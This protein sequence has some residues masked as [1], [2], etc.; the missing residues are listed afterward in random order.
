MSKKSAVK[1]TLG[2]LIGV[3]VAAAGY[4]FIFRKT[5]PVLQPSPAQQSTGV[6]YRNATYGFAVALPESWEG[7]SVTIDTWTGDAMGD[8]LGE[9]PFTTG[10]VVSIHNPRWTGASTYQD[11]PIMVFTIDQWNLLQ[12]EKFHIGAAPIGPSEL[13]RNAAYVFALPARYNYSFPPGY[14]EVD[15]I[16]QSKPLTIFEASGPAPQSQA[17]DQLYYVDANSGKLF[18]F[19]GQTAATSSFSAIP[20]AQHSNFVAFTTDGRYLFFDAK[21][22]EDTEPTLYRYDLEK[23]LTT[24]ILRGANVNVAAISPDN[25]YLV[26]DTGCC[27]GDRGRTLIRLENA[28]KIL[29]TTGGDL[30]WSP[31]SKKLAIEQA[32]VNLY[33]ALGSD[34]TNESIRIIYPRNATAAVETLLQGTYGV[35]YKPLLWKDNDTLIYEKI[36]YQKP[37]PEEPTLVNSSGPEMPNYEYWRKIYEGGTRGYFQINILTGLIQGVDAPQIRK[38]DYFANPQPPKPSPS[39]AW[40]VVYEVPHPGNALVIAYVVRQNDAMKIRLGTT[41]AGDGTAWRPR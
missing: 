4:F 6:E 26:A 19:D 10:S 36:T 2:A 3:A 28:Q 39:G 9:T 1:I 18:I 12:Q 37:F 30:A 13:G 16:I 38:L 25:Q 7:Y 35:S 17:E 40:S 14:E 31:D 23:K 32:A 22:N 29:E 15:R 5:P 41:Y 27:P 24:N 21:K 11:I 8:Q 20:S 34:S 33:Y